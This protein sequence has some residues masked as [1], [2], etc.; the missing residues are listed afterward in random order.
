M[1]DLTPKNLPVSKNLQKS[2]IKVNNRI[3]SVKT[4]LYNMPESNAPLT[5]NSVENVANSMT[6]R[7]D[8][9]AKRKLLQ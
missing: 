7:N 8:A 5:A 3:L 2:M 1:Q 9:E 6:F 4:M